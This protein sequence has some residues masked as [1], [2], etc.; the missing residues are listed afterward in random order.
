MSA[1]SRHFL[2]LLA[3][4]SIAAGF[5]A[6]PAAATPQEVVRFPTAGP[7]G[8]ET[9]EEATAQ[10]S[11]PELPGQAGRLPAVVLLH[12]SWGWADEHEGFRAYARHLREAGFV[13]L[14]LRMFQSHANARKGGA[15]AYLPHLFGSLK[16]LAARPDIDPQRISVAGFSFGGMMAILS[17]TRWANE[18]YGKPGLQFSAHAP[19]YPV[20]W[21]LKANIQGRQSPVPTS[22]W[23]TWTGAPVRIFA[24]ADDDYDDRDPG[25]CQDL[26]NAIPEG[27]RQAFSVQVY[28]G[29]THGWDQP[30]GANFYVKL[31]CKGQG[32]YNRNSP[33]RK[34]TEQSTRDLIE[35][36]S[37]H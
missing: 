25:A 26:V 37:R 7:G 12:S 6:W 22:A 13:A 35:F 31:A 23:Q 1:R 20:C 21:L 24:G 15:E 18:T 8:T 28:P 10:L 27:Q 32:C 2:S 14:E 5:L 3:S 16:F 19:F 34:I 9:G 17:A 36:L 29:A 33:D 11:Y 30:M 4:L